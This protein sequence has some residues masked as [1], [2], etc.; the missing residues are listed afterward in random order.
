MIVEQDVKLM[1]NAYGLLYELE[2]TMR[3]YIRGKMEECYGIHWFEYA[4]RKVLK[5]PPSKDFENLLFSDYESYFK[6]Y[7]VAF[8]NITPTFYTRLH[9]LYPIRNKIAH[10][11]L[12]SP[13]EYELLERYS[14][15][16]LN[17]MGIRQ[18]KL[19]VTL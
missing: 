5:R 7:P 9:Q 3:I 18:H 6:N 19:V 16:L 1:Q 13:S 4:P 2:N 15:F 17:S 11:H 10:N 12:L 8:K 14:I